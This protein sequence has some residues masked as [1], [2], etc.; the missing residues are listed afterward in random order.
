[1]AIFN[2]NLKQC[3]FEQIKNGEKTIEGR[4]NKDKFAKFKIGD[5]ITFKDESDNQFD[6]KITNIN[7][8]NSF[9]SYLEKMTIEKCLPN[10]KTIEEGIEIY[11]QF[12]SIEDEQ[13]YGIMAFTIEVI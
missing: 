9:Q 13:K 11:R 10:V 5:I 4:L 6:A 8:F 1:M 3:Y 12:Y 7:I 2:V